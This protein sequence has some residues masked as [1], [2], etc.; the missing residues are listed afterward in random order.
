MFSS[1]FYKFV[2][3]LFVIVD[4]VIIPAT[5]YGPTATT[6]PFPKPY[7]TSDLANIVPM[8]PVA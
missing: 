5:E 1:F 6:K 3:S 4:S 2:G 8:A 7:V